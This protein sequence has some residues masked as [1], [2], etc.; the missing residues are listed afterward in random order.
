M[1]RLQRLRRFYDR[2]IDRAMGRKGYATARR[3]RKK[4]ALVIRKIRHTRAAAAR[5]RAERD[6]GDLVL[7]DGHQVVAWI[8][9]ELHRARAAGRWHGVV[10]SGYRTP[11]Y[12]ESLCYRMCGRPSCPGRCAGRSTNHAKRGPGQGAVDVTDF[13]TLEAEC[14]RL[15]LRIHNSLPRTDPVHFSASGN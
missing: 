6:A 7:F 3:Y 12:S 11:E 13:W 4:R 1:K 15:G 5:A 2:V 10:V 8:A 14:R 9:V